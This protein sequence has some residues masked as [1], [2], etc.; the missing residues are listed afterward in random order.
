[1]HRPGGETADDGRWYLS[2]GFT[3]TVTADDLAAAF[4]RIK[5]ALTAQGWEFTS[6]SS[7]ADGT[8]IQLDARQPTIGHT[9]S[10]T[11]TKSGTQIAVFLSSR[12]AMPAPGEDP[13]ED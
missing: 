6:Q 11:T 3:V 1:M 8:R 9:A 4:D 13:A 10:L 2:S 7:F 12:C 5:A